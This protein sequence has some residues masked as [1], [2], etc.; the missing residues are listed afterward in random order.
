VGGRSRRR[1]P[2]E[3]EPAPAE[4]EPEPEPEPR[5][6]SLPGVRADLDTRP[7]FPVIT[8]ADGNWR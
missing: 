6:F 7:S 8:V 1:A 4:P 3:P 5:L 2:A